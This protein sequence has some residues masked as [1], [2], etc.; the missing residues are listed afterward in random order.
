LQLAKPKVLLPF[1]LS[2]DTEIQTEPKA[3]NGDPEQDA[4]EDD[5]K[6][7]EIKALRKARKRKD[8]T[9]KELAALKKEEINRKRKAHQIHVQ[10]SDVPSPIET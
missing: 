4:I 5:P 10:G 7:A 3:E 9:P 2:A 1:P 6:G 8:K